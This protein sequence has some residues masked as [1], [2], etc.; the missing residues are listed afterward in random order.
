MP[1]TVGDQGYA[2]VS[3]HVERPLDDRVWARYVSFLGGRPGGFAVASL[4]RPPDAEHGESEAPWLERAR[5][6]AT[7]GPLG[8]H[9]HWTSP[10]HARP[11]AS[12]SPGPAERVRTEGA[13]L[14][15]RGIDAR[16]FCGGAWYMD[17]E[18]A[19]AVAELGYADCTATPERPS[20]LEPGAARIELDQ[21]AWLI[22]P[23]GGRL[24][25]IPSTHSIGE[26]VRALPRALPRV[27]H[28]HFHDYD[29]LD[30]RRRVALEAGL[31]LLALR[32]RRAGL[33]DVTATD[34]RRLEQALA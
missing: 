6:A 29:L 17:A 30:P 1:H 26:L 18:V 10:T 13:W 31:R 19:E 2:L 12:L 27:V 23:G 15:E 8:H 7:L 25:E 14:R 21:P 9:T 33:G 24:L 11:S 34:E 4:L 5:L 28:V 3:C 20:F 16:F 32:R 22:L